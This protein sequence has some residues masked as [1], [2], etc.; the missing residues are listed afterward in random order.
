MKLSSEAG[1]SIH[2]KKKRAALSKLYSVTYT[3]PYKSLL[4]TTL[5]M[6]TSNTQAVAF[7]ELFLQVYMSQRY[8]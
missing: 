1:G 3:F 8:Y 6:E 4:L 7:T 5:S 2:C